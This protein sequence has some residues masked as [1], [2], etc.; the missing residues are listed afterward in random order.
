MGI[1]Y[2][3]YGDYDNAVASFDSK[4]C[5]YNVA[6]AYTLKNDYDNALSKIDCITDKT[7]E[8]YYLRAVVAAR[9]GDVDLM[10]TSL[11]LAVKGDPSYRD[12]AKTDMEFKKY[13]NKVEFQNAIK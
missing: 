3:K 5:D 12:E 9:K 4:Q 1:L 13:W 6:L 10:T 2:I 11:T 8:V 7:P